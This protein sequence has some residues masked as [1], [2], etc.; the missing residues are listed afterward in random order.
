MFE[1]CGAVLRGH[2][3][4]TSGLH[5]GVYWEKMRVVQNPWH[6]ERVCAIIAE[7]YKNLDID[8]VA[9]PTTAGIILAYEIGK[10]LGKPCLFAEKSKEGRCFKRGLE[11]KK[12]DKVLVVD[13]ILTTGKS[14]NEVLDAVEKAGARAVAIAVLVDRSENGLQFGEIPLYCCLR[15]PSIAYEPQKCPLCQ[16]KIPLSILGGA[17][18]K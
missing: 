1:D 14:V 4:L 9:G 7:Y 16:K 18:K 6:T 13:D 3:L 5:S 17:E 11:L 10:K 8:F 15:A 2:F 12:G